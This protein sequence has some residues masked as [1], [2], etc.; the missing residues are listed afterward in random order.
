MRPA[1]LIT[2][3]TEGDAIWSRPQRIQTRNA[4]FLPRFQSLCEQFAFK[5]TY[6][7]N[8]EMVA[9]AEFLEFGRDVLRRGTG[10]IG[11][12]LHAWNSPPLHD[13]T[14]DD[15]HHQPFLVEYPAEVMERKI[16]HLTALL[17]DRFGVRMRSH[18]AGRWVTDARYFALL[19]KYGYTVDCSVT[20]GVSWRNTR[21]DP[22]AHGGTDYS[23]FPALAYYVDLAAPHRPG[24]SALLELPVSVEVAFPL[25]D[26]LARTPLRAIA[27][28]ARLAARRHWLRPNGMN[29]P[30]LL[31]LVRRHVLSGAPYI[32]FVLHSSEFMPG[33]SPAFPT[34][35]SIE[36]LYAHLEQLFTAIA[37]HFRG[38]TLSEY[39]AG[40]RTG[41]YPALG[42]AVAA[43]P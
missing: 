1:F 27:P 13:L 41:D 33:G 24:T 4:A 30:Q 34:V 28:F 6:L 14:G 22:R 12:H 38:A 9:S 3:D 19:V 26:A 23:A 17:E 15:F 37:V 32:E 42:G 35:D 29:L 43:T 18:R 10:E 8:H 21:G 7:T 11:M 20:P 2:I 25:L 31:R 36:R 40:V 16:A 5:P 39:A